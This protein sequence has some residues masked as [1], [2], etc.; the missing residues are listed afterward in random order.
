MENK[1]QQL[2]SGIW[3][4]LITPYNDDLTIDVNGYRKLLDWYLTFK[5]GGLYANCQSSEMSELTNDERLLLITEA[6]KT[7]N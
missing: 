4:V 3:P 2:F 1:N 7:V 6:I 5:I